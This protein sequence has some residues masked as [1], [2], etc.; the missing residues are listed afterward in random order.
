MSIMASIYVPQTPP[1]AWVEH[2]GDCVMLETERGVRMNGVGNVTFPAS[3]AFQQDKLYSVIN[4]TDGGT[5]TCTAADGEFIYVGNEPFSVF[6]MS[7]NMKSVDFSRKG[8][9]WWAQ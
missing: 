4:A 6:E 1:R 7:E 8:N 9:D 3:T 2:D 5:I